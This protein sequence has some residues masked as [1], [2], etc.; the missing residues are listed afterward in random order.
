[1]LFPWKCISFLAWWGKWSLG[2][3]CCKEEHSLG[4][5]LHLELAFQVL[6]HNLYSK[7]VSWWQIQ[8]PEGSCLPLA[9]QLL[10]L[11]GP[12]HTVSS[13]SEVS[14]SEFLMLLNGKSLSTIWWFKR[15]QTLRRTFRFYPSSKDHIVLL[16]LL[17]ENSLHCAK[18]ELGEVSYINY[19][20]NFLADQKC[21]YALYTE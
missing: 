17:L 9:A 13:T 6:S 4:F 15:Y 2:T 5:R 7:P 12:W 11:P 10:F 16:L 14:V 18:V 8:H 1:M 20:L 3:A 19:V 21:E